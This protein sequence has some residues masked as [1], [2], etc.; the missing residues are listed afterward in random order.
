MGLKD[1]WDKITGNTGPK[2]TTASGE[3]ARIP[4]EHLDVSTAEAMVIVEIL[5]ADVDK[6]LGIL[7]SSAPGALATDSTTVIFVPT[8]R[9]VLPVKDPKKGWILP[10]SSEVADKLG[11]TPGDYEINPQIAFVVI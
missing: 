9:E 3:V 2:L 10:L 4:V 5:A 7:A 11:A 8:D 6:V 1:L